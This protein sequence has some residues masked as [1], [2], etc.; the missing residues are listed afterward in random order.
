VS[1]PTGKSWS[2]GDSISVA[3]PRTA[4]PF[5]ARPGDLARLG[6]HRL[7]AGVGGTVINAAM[8]AMLM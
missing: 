5:A 8:A 2:S 3:A 7:L 1:P 4:R 6:S